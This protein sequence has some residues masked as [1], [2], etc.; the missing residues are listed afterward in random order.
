MKSLQTSLLREKFELID[1]SMNIGNKG[2]T[3][4]PSNRMVLPLGGEGRYVHEVFVIRAQNMH[5]CTRIAASILRSF[6]QLGPIKERNNPF[7]WDKAFD[8][9]LNDYERLY[10]KSLW[11]SVYSEGKT[12][13][14]KGKVHPFLDLIERCDH[15]NEGGSYEES[16]A[17][18]EAIFSDKGQA[19]KIDYE[20]NVA[21][22]VNFTAKE[23]RCGIILR[24]ADRTTTFNY[25]VDYKNAPDP[26]HFFSDTLSISA[27]FLEGMQLAFM[28]GMNTAKKMLGHIE[29]RSDEDRK[30]QEA[31]R[32]LTDLE[33]MI[34]HIEE[35]YKP[36]FRPEKPDLHKHVMNAESFGKK[37]LQPVRR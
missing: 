34:D 8:K 24:G 16:S 13:Y 14:K 32:R 5:I 10:N 12:V 26:K 29:R 35:T 23:A 20:G 21:L 36:R 4:A 33:H 27:N 37:I 25:T 31:M 9:I 2:K 17:M 7:D 11:L 1:P 18:A 28:V 19:I 15:D 30:T 6:E 3:T 22:V